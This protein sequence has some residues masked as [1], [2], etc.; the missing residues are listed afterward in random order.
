[1]RMMSR[2]GNCCASETVF[3]RVFAGQTSS[4][5]PFI[6]EIAAIGETVDPQILD[7]A[8]QLERFGEVIQFSAVYVRY[9]I[10]FCINISRVNLTVV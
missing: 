4:R 10:G 1:M 6:W 3:R 9:N 8:I 5:K 7:F 2:R